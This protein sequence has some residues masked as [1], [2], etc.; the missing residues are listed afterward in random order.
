MMK[1]YGVL[2]LFVTFSVASGLRCYQYTTFEPNTCTGVLTCPYGFDRCGS[3]ES[4]GLIDRGCWKKAD[5]I[6]PIQCCDKDLCNGALLTRNTAVLI[7]KGAVLIGNGTFLT[8]KGAVLIGNGTILTGKGAVLTGNGPVP[9]G[10]GVTLLLLSSA[11]MM[12][13][14]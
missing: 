3:F 7:G 5:C 2:V 8:G 12:L 1:L 4:E 13:F 6:S 9:T 10:P 14:I 11:L